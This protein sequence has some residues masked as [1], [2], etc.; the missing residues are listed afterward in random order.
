VLSDDTT[1]RLSFKSAQLQRQ[2]LHQSALYLNFFNSK[3]KMDPAED[4]LN[5][6]T[7]FPDPYDQFQSVLLFMNTIEWSEPWIIG[8]VSFHVVVTTLNVL[9]RKSA[10][11]QALL[12]FLMLILVFVSENLNAV[13]AEHWK[14]FSKHQYFDSDGMF[15][16]IVFSLP[17][18]FNSMLVVVNWL[19]ISSE[20]MT[21]LRKFQLQQ[22]RPR[23]HRK[24]SSSENH[25]N[26][27]NK[28]D[29]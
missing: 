24:S 25:S 9:T 5:I 6:S 18:L 1:Q 2:R 10:T 17:L 27:N 22:K 21:N 29:K 13:A 20:L 11:V 7:I 15:I 14:L 23:E 3:M 12:F 8:L 16:S 28:K 26:S 4:F 19:L